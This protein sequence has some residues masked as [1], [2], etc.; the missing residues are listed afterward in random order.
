[1]SVRHRIEVSAGWESHLC[2]EL[3]SVIESLLP[4]EF[5]PG[6]QPAKEGEL[7]LRMEARDP[8]TSEITSSLTSAIAQSGTSD[9]GLREAPVRFSED[10]Q[11]PFPFRGREL[12]SQVAVRPRSIRGHGDE[13]VLATGEEGPLWAVQVR[14][15]VTHFRSAFTIPA[16]SPGGSLHE[17]LHGDRFMEMLPLIHWLRQVCAPSQYDSPPLRACFIIDDPNLH[18]PR[19]GYVHFKE[20]AASAE[21]EN[22]HVAFATIPLDTWFT[23]GATAELFRRHPTQISLLVHGNNHTYKEL[24]RVRSKSEMVN[25]LAQALDRIDRLERKAK[26]EVARVMTPPHGA[27]SDEMLQTIPECGFEAACISHGSLRA[28]N[29]GKSWTRALGYLP[30]ELIQGCPVMPRWPFT[31]NYLNA[32]LLAAFLGQPLIFRGHHNDLK[33]GLGI[34]SRMA[35]LI[36]NL[37]GVSWG[38][39][40]AHT[41]MNYLSRLDRGT[42]RVK[43][44]APK[45]QIQLPES[46]EALILENS[47]VSSDG[48]W[49]VRRGEGWRDLREGESFAMPKSGGREICIEAAGTRKIPGYTGARFPLADS[50]A[51]VRR[52]LTE[53][54]DRS[55]GNVRNGHRA[56]SHK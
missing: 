54:R 10:R 18:W 5:V 28:H 26:V 41:R 2:G 36:N 33:D 38:D 23:H 55:A 7:F 12:R 48:L 6:R 32:M 24:S 51:L 44:R 20:I 30:S 52:F 53:G 4:I 40:T 43:P 27:C 19:Y 9:S 3:V 22:Y 1:M 39:M 8:E 11:V 50:P 35:Q 16:I 21:R 14:N 47:L 15:G 46:A 31:G 25:L 17:V 37:G 56:L 49:R 29:P 42:L 45:L 13:V 34:L